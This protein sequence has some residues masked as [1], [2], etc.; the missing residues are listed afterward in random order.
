MF[1]R[2]KF[3]TMQILMLSLLYFQSLLWLMMDVL[4]EVW[5]QGIESSLNNRDVSPPPPPSMPPELQKVESPVFYLTIFFWRQN[6]TLKLIFG[7]FEDSKVRLFCG[8]FCRPVWVCLSLSGKIWGN[9]IK[10]RAPPLSNT[11]GIKMSKARYRHPHRIMLPHN[12]NQR[13]RKSKNG[14]VIFEASTRQIPG[15]KKTF[16]INI[17]NEN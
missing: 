11:G 3:K 16:G 7:N 15:K 2:H 1:N 10:S 12:F 8:I 5:K 4:W 9:P 14:S 13:I 6:W 17:C